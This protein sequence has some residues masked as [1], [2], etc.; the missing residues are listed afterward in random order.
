MKRILSLF[1]ALLLCV[2]VTACGK[3]APADDK[4]SEQQEEPKLSVEKVKECVEKFCNENGVSGLTENGVE[5]KDNKTTHSFKYFSDMANIHI[6][7]SDGEVVSIMTIVFPS[8][9][10]LNNP[11]FSQ[12]DLI[13]VAANIATVPF[14]VCDENGDGN[15]FYK[16]VVATTPK[17]ENDT[18][19]YTYAEGD[20]E[21]KMIVNSLSVVVTIEKSGT[22]SSSE[23]QVSGTI[24]NAK[25]QDCSSGHTWVEQTETVHHEEEGHYEKVI[26]DYEEIT[27]YICPQCDKEYKTYSSY[28]THFD[29]HIAEDINIKFLKDSYETKFDSKPIY[30]EE[31]VV[32]KQA[33]DDKVVV[34]YKCSLCGET[35]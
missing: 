30:E 29:K 26:V 14:G 4:S 19:T 35:K 17:N 21:V 18:L 11:S 10:G 32:D 34:G 7:E 8:A 13:A 28:S 16:R 27:T 15:A 9:L 1:L 20:W 33:Y 24:D 22:G 25:P 6:A 5:E 31:W 23:E 2:C 12:S 3:D